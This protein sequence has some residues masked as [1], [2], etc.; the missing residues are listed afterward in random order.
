MRAGELW[1]D[2]KK[3]AFDYKL[4]KLA[5]SCLTGPIKYVLSHPDVHAQGTRD[6]VGYRTKNIDLIYDTIVYFNYWRECMETSIAAVESADRAK[7]AIDKLKQTVDDFRSAIK[8]DVSSMKAA[9]ERVQNEVHQMREKY[10]QAQ[11]MLTT[12]EF[13]QA[14]ANA[15][16]MAAA[17]TAIQ[18][19]TETKVSVAVFSGG[20]EEIERNA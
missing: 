5:P 6:G 1:W 16:R 10:K 12:P 13:M 4:D 20:K 17:L 3:E 7:V 18:Q 19:L 15:E 14:I 8:N 2:G 9:S 11:D